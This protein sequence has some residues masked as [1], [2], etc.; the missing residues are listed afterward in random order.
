MARPKVK[1]LGVGVSL[2]GLVD[3]RTGRGVL[4]PNVPMTDGHAPAAD[5]A[6]RLGVPGTLLQEQHALC[7][8][9]RHY[10]LAKGI[11][12]FAVFD[13]GTGIGLGVMLGGRLLKGH[14][15]LAGEIG[16]ITVSPAGGRRCGCGN[17]GCLETVASES[18]LAYHAGRKLH[19]PVT[20]DEVIELMRTKGV[21]LSKELK[22][23]GAYLSIGIGAVVNLFNPSVVFVH[24]PIF[25]IEPGLLD[26][27]AV[28][29]RQHSVA[30]SYAECRIVRAQGTKRQGAAAG[31][32]QQVMDSVAPEVA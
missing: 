12:D 24:S 22:E 10:G 9:E 25:D 11:D 17:F 19:R 29:V 20:A 16:H 26:A 32:V 28:R 4:S 2:P 14:S 30:P 1:T 6:Q 23:V 18:A 27:V 21:D 31:V 3:Y 5:L 15:G 13:V 8:A 7:L